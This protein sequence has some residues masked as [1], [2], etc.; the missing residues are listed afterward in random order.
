MVKYFGDSDPQSLNAVFA[1][2]ADPS[3]RAILERLADEPSL[4]AGE[5]AEPLTEYM[6]APAVSK[7]LKV[8]RE[9]GLIS[10]TKRGRERHC[11][12]EGQALYDAAAWIGAQ[13]RFWTQSLDRLADHLESTPQ[14]DPEPK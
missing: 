7:H 4:T 13:R 2:L 1:A 5:L 12:L 9:A 14:S 8:L 10:Q 6:S 11:Q 3:R